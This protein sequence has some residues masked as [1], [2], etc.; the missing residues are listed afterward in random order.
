MLAA[1]TAILAELQL[2]RSSFL[3]LGGGVIPLFAL[4]A[5]KRNDISHVSASFC[6]N[7]PV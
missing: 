6:M 3:V 7:P 4:C 5:A 2:A 1:E